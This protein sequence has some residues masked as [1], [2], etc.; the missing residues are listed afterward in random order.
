[1][2]I[3]QRATV[4]VL[5]SLEDNVICAMNVSIVHVTEYVM[6]DETHGREKVKYSV[7]L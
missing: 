6:F 2:T 5:Y 3:D 4:I 7:C 1:M